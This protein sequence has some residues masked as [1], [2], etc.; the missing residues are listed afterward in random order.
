[1]SIAPLYNGRTVSDYIFESLGFSSW[2]EDG[3]HI[4]VIPGVVLYFAALIWCAAAFRRTLP[5][6][7]LF[8][9]SVWGPL[10]VSVLPP[11][12]PFFP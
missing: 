7:G 11:N 8:L 10:P 6:A 9:F 5:A 4:S 3:A 12:M 2:L 1:M